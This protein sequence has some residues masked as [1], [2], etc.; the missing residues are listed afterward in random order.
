[1]KKFPKPELFELI[2]SLVVIA[3]AGV[4]AGRRPGREVRRLQRAA[5]RLRRDDERE[6]TRRIHRQV[7]RPRIHRVRLQV[8]SQSCN[9]LD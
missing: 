4:R 1:M 7:G 2:P 3:G 8:V 9:S 6:P 5:H